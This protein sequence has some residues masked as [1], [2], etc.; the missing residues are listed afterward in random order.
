MKKNTLFTAVLAVVMAAFTFS[1]KQQEGNVNPVKTNPISTEV[2]AQFKSLGIDAR[3]AKF[4]EV[5]NELTGEKQTGY[6]LEKDLFVSEKQ[7]AEML[8][9]SVKTGPGGEQYRTTNLVNGTRTIRVIGYTGGSFALTSKMRSGLQQAVASYNALPLRL[10]FSLSFA[11]STNAD[12]VVYK[13]SGGAGGSAGFPSGGNP[14]KW[15]RINSGT[16][17]YS[18]AVNRHVIA[19]EIGH[20]I[21]FRH[22][23]WFNRS[24]SCG[25]GGN[26]GTAG[27]GAIHIPGT[28]TTNVTRNTS[29]MVSCFNS[30]SNGVFT[31]SDVTALNFLY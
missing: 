15:V 5:T 30:G 12:I 2:I 25:S 7:L 11:T 8:S 1:C 14:Y 21:G 3:D 23:D 19:H 10:S 27:V 20:C 31:S 16:D 18:T 17:A 13:V 6:T 9:S 22:T 4:G 24:I 26:E 28:P 29:I